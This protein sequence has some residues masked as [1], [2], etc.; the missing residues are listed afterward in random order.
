MNGFFTALRK[1]ARFRGR[2]TRR[3]YW[4]FMLVYLLITM[5]LAVADRV[6]GL[7]VSPGSKA[8]LLGWL[9]TL[10]MLLP[11][12]AVSIRRLHDRDLSAWFMLLGLIP[13]LGSAILLVLAALP[14]TRGD[15][16]HGPDPLAEPET[17]A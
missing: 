14:G 8:G 12:L 4:Q 13:L 10:S 15:N 17:Q 11:S 16:R 7:M 3:E 5:A 6:L 1:Y 2:S 9:F